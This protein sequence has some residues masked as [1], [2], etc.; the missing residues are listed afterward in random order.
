MFQLTSDEQGLGRKSPL[1]EKLGL[2]SVPVETYTQQCQFS[3]VHLPAHARHNRGPCALLFTAVAPRRT[4]QV[5]PQ[6]GKAEVCWAPR[7]WHLLEVATTY[8]SS[9]PSCVW[10]PSHGL[11]VTQNMTGSQNPGSLFVLLFV[12]RNILWQRKERHLHRCSHG[13]AHGTVPSLLQFS[14]ET[15][16]V[17]GGPDSQRRLAVWACPC[18]APAT[19]RQLGQAKT[20]SS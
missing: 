1:C 19:N 12:R 3:E 20:S 17:P 5:S 6:P 2:L 11:E 15:G 10:K 8:P 4:L 9:H 13:G 16:M 14:W 7:H 18:S